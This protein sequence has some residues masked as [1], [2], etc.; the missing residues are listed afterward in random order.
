[1]IGDFK[2]VVND[3][4]QPRLEIKQVRF[5]NSKKVRIKKK[6]AKRSCNF[7]SFYIDEF[8]VSHDTIFVNQKHYDKLMVYFND[9]ST[10]STNSSPYAFR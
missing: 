5:P 1:M 7:K 8:I 4:I 9:T 6:W 3:F 2:I 10:K